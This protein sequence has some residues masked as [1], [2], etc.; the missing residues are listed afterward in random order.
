MLQSIGKMLISLSFVILLALS[1]AWIVKK[2][3]VKNR[4]LGG[5]YIDL[6]SS[7]ALSQKSQV[8]L[9]RVGSAHYLV[10]EGGQSVSLISKVDLLDE[11]QEEFDEYSPDLLE[12]PPQEPQ[13]VAS[14]DDRLTHWQDALDDRKMKQEVNAS[15]LFLRGLSQRLKNKGGGDG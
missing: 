4:T 3:F 14:F 12:E 2:Y 11:P 1:A 13:D 10:G 8:H 5:D 7:Y 9:I 6:L 15:L